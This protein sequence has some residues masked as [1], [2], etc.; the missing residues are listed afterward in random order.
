M[1]ND[2]LLSKQEVVKIIKYRFDCWLESKDPAYSRHKQLYCI[3]SSAGFL[4][5]VVVIPQEAK[6]ILSFNR[7]ESGDAMP[8]DRVQQ[9]VDNDWWELQRI[10]RTEYYKKLLDEID[11]QKG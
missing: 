2:K 3:L 8:L 9:A 5:V 6:L 7:E 10:G 4:S 11:G 1:N